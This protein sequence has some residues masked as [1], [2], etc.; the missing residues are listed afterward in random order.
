[1][2]NRF[3]PTDDQKQPVLHPVIY[4]TMLLALFSTG[5]CFVSGIIMLLIN[6]TN[7]IWDLRVKIIII[8][9]ILVFLGLGLLLLWLIRRR[10]SG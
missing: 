8:A 10:I 6:W 1:M 9:G 7:P 2:R 4:S 5:L 3:T